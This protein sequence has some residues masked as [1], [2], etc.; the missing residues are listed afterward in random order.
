MRHTKKASAVVDSVTATDIPH[1]IRQW[2]HKAYYNANTDSYAYSTHLPPD[3]LVHT[4]I[5]IY[6]QMNARKYTNKFS[7]TA[8]FD[9]ALNLSERSIW[10]SSCTNKTLRP[11][12]LS[13]QASGE[14]NAC[15]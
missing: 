2:V 13:H 14:T 3:A 6:I 15:C 12:N 7:K 1:K 4:L 11:L 10:Q 5:L 9:L 8:K